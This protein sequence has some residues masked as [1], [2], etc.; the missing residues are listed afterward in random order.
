MIAGDNGAHFIASGMGARGFF[1]ST[2]RRNDK[3]IG[4]ENEF[5][6]KI[7]TRLWNRVM[8]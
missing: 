5:R 8:K 6:Q 4:S 2:G 1:E 7:L 3:L